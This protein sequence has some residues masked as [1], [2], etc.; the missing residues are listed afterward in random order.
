VLAADE[1][2]SRTDEPGKRR[3]PW[4]ALVEPPA[5]ALGHRKFDSLP[6]QMI[7]GADARSGAV[8]SLVTRARSS[9]VN[10]RVVA[11]TGLRHAFRHA[12]GRRSCR[13]WSRSRRPHGRIRLVAS[14]CARAR[15]GRRRHLLFVRRSARDAERAPGA[16]RGSRTG[17]EKR[18]HLRQ[19]VPEQG[20]FPGPRENFPVDS[21]RFPPKAA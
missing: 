16:G 18:A 13:T 14:S 19:F 7:D 2:S 6:R 4:L 3:D 1:P 9:E 12:K 20:N 11:R 10:V 15:H 17:S 5:G 8:H 21:G